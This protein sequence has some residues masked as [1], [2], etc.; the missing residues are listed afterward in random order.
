MKTGAL[1][2]KPRQGE[3]LPLNS[4]TNSAKIFAALIY[5]SKYFCASILNQ[6]GCDSMD[7]S[8][9]TARGRFNYRVCAV[10]LRKDRL[11]TMQDALSPY[12]YLPGG[13][14]KL[15]ETAE[16]ALIRELQ[17]ELHIEAHIVR[18]LWFCQSFFTDAA[19]GERFHELCLYY[20]AEDSE[21]VLPH[22]SFSIPDNGREHAFAWIPLPDL[23]AYN[24]VPAFI[25]DRIWKLPEKAEFITDIQA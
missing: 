22:D 13:R 8:F 11:L 2:L 17:E 25:K 1:P 15:H 12:A 3:R 24:L 23:Q 6:K 10:I 18:P 14:V 7:I 19:N 21:N 20:L 16:E 9:K 5:G 4:H